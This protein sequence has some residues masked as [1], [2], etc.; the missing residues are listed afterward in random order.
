[1][2]EASK[3][4]FARQLRRLSVFLLLLWAMTARRLSAEESNLPTHTESQINQLVQSLC[5]RLSLQLDMQVSIKPHNDLMVSVEP[6]DGLHNTYVLSFDQQFLNSLSEEEL[7]AAI[8]HEL[9][10]VWI[11]THHPY[12]QTEALANEIA[13]R[14]VSR[15]S[16]TKV[17]AKLWA[18][19]GTGGNLAEFLGN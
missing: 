2:H 1:M 8:A 4:V 16:L 11:F 9:G 17:Y 13:M 19:L 5:K 18:H 12:L 3:K 15:E 10:H 6:V 7:T 14:A